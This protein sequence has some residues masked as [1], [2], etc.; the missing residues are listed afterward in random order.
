MKETSCDTP[1]TQEEMDNIIAL[2]EVLR[3]INNR[4]LKEGVIRRENCK[5][6]WPEKALEELKTKKRD[7]LTKRIQKSTSC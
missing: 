4:L 1:F 5:T 7:D 2:G 3:S 6:V